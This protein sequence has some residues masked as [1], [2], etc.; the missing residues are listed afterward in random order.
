MATETLSPAP[1]AKRSGSRLFDLLAF[2]RDPLKFLTRL[3]REHGDIVPFRM[4][5]QHVLLLNHPELVKDALVTRADC[6]HKGR[7]LQ[8]S[9]RL[10]GE[11]LLTSEGEHHRRQRRLAQP[12]FHR[13][14][15]ESY[16]AAM[17]EYAA[18]DSFRWRDGQTLDISHEMMRLTLAIVGKTLFD[19][20]VESDTDE[21]GGALTEL[22]ELFQMLLLPYS[23]YLERLPLPANRRFTRARAKLDAVIYRIINE[24][25]ASGAD[26]GDLLSMLLLAQDE[27]GASG[28]MTDEQLRDEALTIFLA[29]HETTANALAWTWYLLSQN[30]DAEAK[31]HA[32]LDAVLKDGRL[33][34]VEDLPQLRYTEMVLAES[35]R[36]Y[37]PAWVVGRLAVKEYAVGGHVAA[38]GTLVLISQYVLHRDPRFFPDP[39]RFDPERWT[40]E[41]KEAR[42]PYAYFPFGGGARRC[43][44]EGFAWMEGTLIIAALARRWRMR[45]VPEHPVV[46]HPRMT[47]RAK[48]GIRMK[49]EDRGKGKG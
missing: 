6:F 2:R 20:D 19:A 38:E 11:G 15:I 1:R 3:A 18:R 33:P 40:P 49:M 26:R 5:P 34:T 13:K 24:R 25:R 23:E 46:P 7:A 9:K 47:L 35:M 31:L 28:S 27:E 14:R 29:G 41:A 37:P 39:L 32:E 44:G 43:I 17:V 36:L 4:G 10:L 48:H 16:G 12:A 8:R 45:L 22:L 30:L 42:P 21:I